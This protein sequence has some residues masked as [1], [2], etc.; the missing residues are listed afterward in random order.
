MP[1]HHKFWDKIS[2]RYA[3]SS[4][5]DPDA[6]EQKVKTIESHLTPDME[7][8]EFGC[9]TGSTAIRL[10]P[11]AKHILATDFSSEMLKIAREKAVESNIQNVTFQQSSIDEFNA[12]DESYDIIMGMS[13]LHLL[14]DE[15]ATIRKVYQLLKPGG[16]FISNTFCMGDNMRFIKY[17]APA[18]QFFGFLP[19]LNIFT[20]GDLIKNLEKPGFKIDHLWQSEKGKSVFIVAGKT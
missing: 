1:K 17:I 6:Y 14:K 12:P 7:V 8:M 9:G 13:I 3:K 20:K 10:A 18:G 4:L 16:L 15:K 2:K 11:L 19:L 5:S